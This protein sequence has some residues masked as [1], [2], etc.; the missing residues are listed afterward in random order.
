[1]LHQIMGVVRK[2]DPVSIR[3]LVNNVLDPLAGPMFPYPYTLP[4]TLR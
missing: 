2:P 4:G 1:M 3:C